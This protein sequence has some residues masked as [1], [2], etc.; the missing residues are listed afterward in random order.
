MHWSCNC[1]TWYACC[2]FLQ[3]AIKKTVS[4]PQCTINNLYIEEDHFSLYYIS[5]THICRVC[6]QCGVI[7]LQQRHLQTYQSSPYSF[8]KAKKGLGIVNTRLTDQILSHL[9]LDRIL[10]TYIAATIKIPFLKNI[11]YT[12]TQSNLSDKRK[13]FLHRIFF[14]K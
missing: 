14:L 13:I 2:E 4:N 12:I 5:K 3:C 10:C 1:F 8:Q 6:V 7:L 11:C 9:H